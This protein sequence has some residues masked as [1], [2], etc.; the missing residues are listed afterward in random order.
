LDQAPT[1]DVAS[2]AQLGEIDL[3]QGAR[4]NVSGTGGGRVV[5]RGDRLLV[6]NATSA[7]VTEGEAHGTA[8]GIDIEVAG[9]V[10]LTGGA[11]VNSDTRGSGRG[12]MV[13]VT[14][15]DTV[16]ITG[17]DSGIF[18]DAFGSGNAGGVVIEAGT[19]RL[20]EGGQIT[21][22]THDTGPGGTIRVSAEDAII[23]SGSGTRGLSLIS[24]SAFGPGDAGAIVVDVPTLKLQEGGRIISVTGSTMAGAGAGGT[25]RVNA[26]DIIVT[27]TSRAGF[28]SG[29]LVTSTSDGRTFP[30]NTNNV[31]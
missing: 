12:G 19:L 15:R 17:S 9:D 7:A 31:L 14:A 23:I 22:D 20:Q 21:S 29:I 4:I 24:S 27:G 1:F 28:A 10:I 25:M 2:F 18:S 30:S 5:I 26:A 13:R 11:R 8:V 6:D 3:S 16:T